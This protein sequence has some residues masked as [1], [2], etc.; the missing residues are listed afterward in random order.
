MVLTASEIIRRRVAGLHQINTITSTEIEEVYEPLEEGL[1]RVVEKKRLSLL[2]IKLTLKPEEADLK[3]VG[4]LA[5]LDP[6]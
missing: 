5:P 2:L 4:Y 3:S 1:V 6:S